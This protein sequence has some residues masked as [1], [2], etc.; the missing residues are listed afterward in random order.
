VSYDLKIWST[1]AAK[2]PEVLP[3]LERWQLSGE[4]WTRQG[5]SWELSIGRSDQ[6]LPEDVPPE[7]EKLLPG[8][9]FLTE[10]NLSPI[11]A[12][13]SAKTLMMKVAGELARSAHGVVVDP[14]MD[15]ITT[16]KGVSRL[17][18]LGSSENA[19]VLALSWWFTSTPLVHRDVTLLVEALESSLPEALP[20]RYGLYEPPQ[21]Q[22][23]TT[24]RDHFIAFFR[25]SCGPLGLVV[26]YPHAPIAN[27]SL[28]IPPNVG[29]SRMGYRCGRLT[30][31][32][33]AEALTQ[34]GW[35]TGIQRA[36][37][38]ISHAVRPFYG[39]VRTL[40]GFRRM[41]GRY[42][43]SRQTE[44]HPV[45]SWWWAGVPTIPAHAVV[46]GDPYRSLLPEF[47][48]TGRAE[49]ELC[50]ASVDDWRAEASVLNGI[51][52]LPEGTAQV[53][54]EFGGPDR[55]RRYPKTWPFGDPWM[56]L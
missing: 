55:E 28:S 25:D 4:S 38:R 6:V 31:E 27:V 21:H 33:D 48:S 9:A 20:R 39:D 26:W 49:A 11:G 16:V 7:V 45:C 47:C 8:I 44:R 43:S 24:G 10:L 56:D 22:F 12:A 51:G 46:L 54:P 15:T 18:S 2:V 5:T 29:G 42:W 37:R 40:R 30:I 32:V 23:L 50:F 19:S 52:R 3:E 34:P 1:D 17:E 41:R 36:W 13:P 14:Q 35:A 53:A